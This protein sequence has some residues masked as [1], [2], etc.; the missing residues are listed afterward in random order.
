[1]ILFS[2]YNPILAYGNAAFYRDALSAG[3]D[4][5]LVVDLPPEEAGE[6]LSQWE[7]KEL[8]F[9]RL[10]APTT[11]EER[12]KKIADEASGFLYL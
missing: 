4:G 12:M 9:I 1:M 11:P 10:V 6:M 8:D 3:A 5:L 7:G 2:Y